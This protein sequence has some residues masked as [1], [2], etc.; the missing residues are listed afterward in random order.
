FV[1]V[2]HHHQGQRHRHSSC[3]QSTGRN[4]CSSRYDGRLSSTY[5]LS[6]GSKSIQDLRMSS[7]Y[8]YKTVRYSPAS[9]SSA[10]SSSSTTSSSSTSSS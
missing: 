4:R 3:I 1:V 7:I 6:R 10:A 8:R 2:G 9:P 5:G